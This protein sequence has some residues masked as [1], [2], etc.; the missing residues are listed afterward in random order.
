[1]RIQLSDDGATHHVCV[2]LEAK[3][4]RPPVRAILTGKLIEYSGLQLFG[5]NRWL[6]FT[7][8]CPRDVWHTRRQLYYPLY[9]HPA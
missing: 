6:R 2:V 7:P 8:A 5:G 9:R 1:M 4:D 3:R